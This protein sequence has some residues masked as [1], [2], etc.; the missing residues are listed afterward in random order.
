MRQF[1][2]QREDLNTWPENVSKW[3]RNY[4]LII[5]LLV[6]CILTTI[7]LVGLTHLTTTIALDNGE[8]KAFQ[9]QMRLHQ[10][11]NPGEV[12]LHQT[13]ATHILFSGK[14][15]PLFHG[16]SAGM[17]H[18]E[19][20]KFDILKKQSKHIKLLFIAGIEGTGHHLFVSLMEELAKHDHTVHMEYYKDTILPLCLHGC[21][22]WELWDQEIDKPEL[23]PRIKDEIG[24]NSS[25]C[26]CVSKQLANISKTLPDGSLLVLRS[27][28]YPFQD[29][30]GTRRRKLPWIYDVKVVVMRRKWVEAI[31]SA[32]LHRFGDC[33]KRA[34]FLPRLLSELQTE[35]LQ[36]DPEFWILL[37]FNDLVSR[38]VS[39][40]NVLQTFLNLKN[41]KTVANALKDSVRVRSNDPKDPTYKELGKS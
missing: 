5:C 32:C 18:V 38:P 19:M 37:D 10:R 25:F 9:W 7:L 3:K 29:V 17:T 41:E 22:T 8:N 21:F 2:F 30:P 1:T 28:S 12:Q 33:D 31:V 6:I 13:N 15:A 36:I 14:L 20:K 24:D 16:L 34:L 39:Y 35:L 26:D 23:M 40:A 27:Y 4:V 11:V